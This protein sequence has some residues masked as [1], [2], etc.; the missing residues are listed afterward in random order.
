[1][2]TIANYYLLTTITDLF[3]IITNNYYNNNSN[4]LQFIINVAENITFLN[5]VRLLWY[6]HI[7]VF[8][9]FSQIMS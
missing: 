9:M 2:Q 3:T 4:S 8:R 7:N 1:M 6:C 5:T